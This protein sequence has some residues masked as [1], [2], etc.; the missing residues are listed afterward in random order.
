MRKEVSSGFRERQATRIGAAIGL[1]LIM[2]TL[3]GCGEREELKTYM[4]CMMAASQLGDQ[5]ATKMI[6]LKASEFAYQENFDM[7][8][9]DMIMMRQEI[10]EELDVAGKSDMMAVFT[11]IKIYNSS[12]CQDIHKQPTISPP[13]GFF[14]KIMYY[15]GYFFY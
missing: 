5:K 11:F 6:G 1:S 9:R 3:S 10:L 8:N 7:S 13:F 12:D 15:L 14:S 4:T 2:I